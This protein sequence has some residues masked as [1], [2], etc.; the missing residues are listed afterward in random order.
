MAHVCFM[1]VVVTMWGFVGVCGNICCVAGVV[2]D[3]VFNLEMLKYVLCLCRGC[4][5]YC[6]FCLNCETWG[7]RCSRIGSLSA[8]SC[9]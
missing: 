1:S 3:S 8:F 6:V 2:K 7:C 9:R 5:G 4:D